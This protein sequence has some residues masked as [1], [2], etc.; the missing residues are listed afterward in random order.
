ME[1]G[2][3]FDVI[4]TSGSFS[5]MN[6]QRIMRDILQGIAYLHTHSIVHRDIKPENVLCKSSKSFPLT[7]KIADLG[8][9]G[10][11][12]ESG[13]MSERNQQQMIGTAAYVAPEI[14]RKEPYGAGVDVWASGVLLYIMLTGKMP[15]YGNDESEVLKMILDGE[16]DYSLPEFEPISESAKSLLRSLLQ[17]DPNRR[18][19]AQAALNHRWIEDSSIVSDA[20][21]G[22][23]YS[24]LHSS[25]RKFR[26]AV[27]A[28]ASLKKMSMLRMATANAVASGAFSTVSSS[29]ITSEQ[30]PKTN[31]S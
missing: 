23:D 30:Q 28:V 1:G 26:R 31:P 8:L 10:F 14:V 5:E 3:L 4:A 27:I 7:V 15:F 11:L 13:E 16:V 21:L 24:N 20:P 9:A 12:G 25:R 6:A 17:K 18:L 2:E 29:S 19:T 22:N